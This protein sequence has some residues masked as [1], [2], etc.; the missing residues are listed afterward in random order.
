MARAAYAHRWAADMGELMPEALITY[1][2]Q[3]AKTAC[4]GNCKKAWGISQRPKIQLSEDE[5]DVVF[6]ADDELN[7]AP[8]DPGTYEGQH[9]KPSSALYFPNKWC[10]RECERSATSYPGKHNEQLVVPNFGVRIFNQPSKHAAQQPHAVDLA[11][12]PLRPNH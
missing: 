2:G 9:G 5:D 10:V 6:L 11:S 8:D 1:M 7:D 3:P 4:D 12:A